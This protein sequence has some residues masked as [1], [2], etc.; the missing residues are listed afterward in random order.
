M[1]KKKRDQGS[2]PA[3]IA[4]NRK[5][6]HDYFIEDT[7]EAGIALEGWEAKSLR[8]RR[9]QL[10]ESYVLIKDAEA[11]LIGAHISPL[12]TAS[13]HISPDPVRTR[14]L[15]MHRRE[16]DRLVGAVERSGYTIVP[17]SM[18]WKRGRAKLQL[19]LARGKKQHDK[20][21]A[22]RQRDWQREQQRILK[23]G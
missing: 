6:R 2:S 1:G 10:K 23:K 13:T 14:K 4:V 9:L 22:E 17:L 8:D 21:Q 3:T 18:Y 16:L 5:A 12:A 15:L 11:W 19:G 7:F 20:R